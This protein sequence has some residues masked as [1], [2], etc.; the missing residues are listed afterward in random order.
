MASSIR[1][2]T[3]YDLAMP[4]HCVVCGKHVDQRST[5][6]DVLEGKAHQCFYGW[7]CAFGALYKMMSEDEKIQHFHSDRCCPRCIMNFEDEEGNLC[8]GD[9]RESCCPS[10][11]VCE[12][13]ECLSECEENENAYQISHDNI[14]HEVVFTR[15]KIRVSNGEET[16]T[17]Y[18]CIYEGS[19]EHT[20]W[21]DGDWDY[22][23]YCDLRL[24]YA[25]RDMEGTVEEISE[26]EFFMNGYAGVEKGCN[27]TD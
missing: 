19:D 23:D 20:Q 18:R 13:C 27:I 16:E 22:E 10:C 7:D 1:F 3:P 25:G 9:I 24:D 12:D 8:K 15:L 4:N 17:F 26:E 2:S 14:F 5:V 6:N 11:R 21:L